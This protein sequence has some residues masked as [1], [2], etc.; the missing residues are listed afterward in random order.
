MTLCDLTVKGIASLRLCTGNTL[1]DETTRLILR[2]AQEASGGC[3]IFQQSEQFLE[4]EADKLLLQ[5]AIDLDS[6]GFKM[7][8][9]K[10]VLETLKTGASVAIIVWGDPL[11][12]TEYCSLLDNVINDGYAFSVVHNASM[13]NS[14]ASCGLQLYTFGE[15]VHFPSSSI[16]TDDQSLETLRKDEDS[17][18]NKI[19]RN[20]REGWHT[21]CLLHC[22]DCT[23]GSLHCWSP[24]AAAGLLLAVIQHCTSPNTN[25]NSSL[26][27]ST[28]VVGVAGIGS[29]REQLVTGPLVTMATQQFPAGPVSALIVTGTTH[30]IEMDCLKALTET[31]VET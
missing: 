18:Y 4:E 11:V 10:T 17:F 13:F 8:A 15:T 29:A 23:T 3:N 30:P 9:S 19:V 14:I 20:H 22:V 5:A 1:V 24:D 31:P 12:Y 21:L 28:V 26:S 27:S 16:A 25:T 2:A 7:S 6:P